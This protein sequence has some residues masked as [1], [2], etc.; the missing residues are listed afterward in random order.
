MKSKARRNQCNYSIAFNLSVVEQ[1]EKEMTY[2]CARPLWNS[3][4]SNSFGLTSEI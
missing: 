3:G 2:K 4:M 1:I